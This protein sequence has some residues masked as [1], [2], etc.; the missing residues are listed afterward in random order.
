MSVS[1]L[2]SGTITL[3]PKM[4]IHEPHKQYDLTQDHIYKLLVSLCEDF[5][6]VSELT[7]TYNIHYHIMCTFNLREH[8]YP[9]KDWHNAFRNDSFVGFTK[10]EQTINDQL[11]KDYL[12]KD[13]I[14]SYN[15]TG[16][17]PI[18]YDSLDVFTS[19]ERA[20]FGIEW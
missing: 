7:K 17:R 1:C 20:D 6:F 19:D 3:R 13:L 10:I 8:K 16:R 14:H 12:K 15:C 18:I 4:Y 9:L 11:W 2:Y 5:T